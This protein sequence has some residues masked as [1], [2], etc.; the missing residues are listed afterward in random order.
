MSRYKPR[1]A[2]SGRSVGTKSTTVKPLE[3]LQEENLTSETRE[4]QSNMSW[5]CKQV[6]LN[7]VLTGL[8]LCVFAF[9]HHVLPRL[10]VSQLEK[11]TSVTIERP[12]PSTTIDNA[13]ADNGS[14]DTQG[15]ALGESG[16]GTGESEQAQPSGDSD[17]QQDPAVN[18]TDPQPDQEE[19]PVI[20]DDRTEWQKKFADKFTDE[21]VLTENSY[22]SPNISITITKHIVE[23]PWDTVCYI[24]DIYVAQID[25]FQTYWALGEFD[26][27]NS[28]P[29]ER[30]ADK[31]GGIITINGDYA[32]NQRTGLLIRNG[33]LYMSEQTTNDICVLYYDGTMET[34][35][36]D[37]Y[38]VDDILAKSPYQT[39]KFGP[40][41]LDENGQPKTEFNT[42]AQIAWE[43]PRTAIG[44]YEPGHYCF[45][46]CDG[47]QSGYSRGLE[48]SQ[49]A[50]LFADLGCKAAYN[51]DG[52]ASAIMTF[53][54]EVYNRPSNG[55]RDSGDIL[56]ICELPPEEEDAVPPENDSGEIIT[57]GEQ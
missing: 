13:A 10:T 29:P 35:A 2:A 49:L 21:I 42:S 38:V 33:E 14:A 54:G 43:N 51:L 5:T 31:T 3:A 47:R 53:D 45:V 1:H 30:L 41:L 32:N 57:D 50:Q 26:F 19:E 9:F 20:V 16:V 24:A 12:T 22:S 34:Y 55:G 37:E 4:K 36:A 18:D 48:M 15:A 40:E 8:V 27:Y 25:N 39:W 7:L 23:E 44:Y 6:V 11:P 17:T 28:E 46:V 56:L 52:G